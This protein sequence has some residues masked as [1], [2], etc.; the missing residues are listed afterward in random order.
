MRRDLSQLLP[1]NHPSQSSL[2]AAH[3]STVL[4]LYRNCPRWIGTDLGTLKNTQFLILYLR[5]GQVVLL[6]CVYI[7]L[8]QH[9]IPSEKEWGSKEESFLRIPSSIRT[10]LKV[11]ISNSIGIAAFD[12][13]MMSP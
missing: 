5:K 12:H 4:I 2:N 6:G 11:L 13:A 1:A 7:L 9:S 3:G 10:I 8:Q